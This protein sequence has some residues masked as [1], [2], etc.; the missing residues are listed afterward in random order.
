L[1]DSQQRIK[2]KPAHQEAYWL[3]PLF[4]VG[5][6]RRLE[7][8]DMY[9]VLPEDAS[10]RLGEELQRFWNQEVEQAVKDLRPPS[11]AR[12]LIHCY[13]KPYSLIGMYIFIEVERVHMKL[14]WSKSKER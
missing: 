6:K 10:Q 3:N 11:L 8:D 5:Y 2:P 1:I 13:W 4:R 7:E 9:R 12:A 14:V